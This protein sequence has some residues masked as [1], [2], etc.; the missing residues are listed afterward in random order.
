MLNREQVLNT[1]IREEYLQQKKQY[2]FK[3]ETGRKVYWMFYKQGFL[4]KLLCDNGINHNFTPM[5][6][7]T[8]MLSWP[9]TV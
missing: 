7:N 8:V 6:G 1:N 5:S 4:Y 9:Q 2:L 3:A